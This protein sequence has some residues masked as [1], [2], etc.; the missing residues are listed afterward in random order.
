M[1]QVDNSQRHS[2]TQSLGESREVLGEG[3]NA[4]S[5]MPMPSESSLVT[6][7][8]T[9][10]QEKQ[11][12]EEEDKELCVSPINQTDNDNHFESE[13]EIDNSK[14]IKEAS[15]RA[16]RDAVAMKRS[17]S[18]L[19]DSDN[20]G[21]DNFLDEEDIEPTKL[22]PRKSDATHRYMEEAS[23]EASLLSPNH[24]LLAPS[25]K[26]HRKRSSVSRDV[27]DVRL[28][29][30]SSQGL[31]DE[32][33][34]GERGHFL[35]MNST[36]SEGPPMHTVLAMP[37][38]EDSKED[39]TEIEDLYKTLE[40]CGLSTP[41]ETSDSKFPDDVVLLHAI[42]R[43]FCDPAVDIGSVE[44][45]LDMERGEDAQSIKLPVDVVI[46]RPSKV[47][48]KLLGPPLLSLP[49]NF[50]MGLF[51]ILIR[52]LTNDTDAE[53]NTEILA[54]CP[55][56]DETFAP[57][58]MGGPGILRRQRTTSTASIKR[59]SSF[60]EMSFN[61]SVEARKAD[62]MYT[63]VRL[64]RNWTTAVRQMLHLLRRILQH[65]SRYS[66]LLPPLTRLI[67]LLCSG[68]I[69]V[70]ELRDLLSMAAETKTAPKVQL[71]LVRALTVAAAGAS[72]SSFLVG[73]ASPSHFFSF[74]SGPGMRRKVYL[75][76]PWPFKNDLGMALWFR[77]EYFSK[78]ST[79]LRV[80]DQAGNG[81]EISLLPLSR[82]AEGRPT[83]TVLAIS[84]LEE[85]KVVNSI[86]VSKCILHPRVWYHVGI[87]HTRSRL[88]GVFSLGSREQVSVMLDGKN[89]LT[90]TLKFPK[91]EESNNTSLHLSFGDD[92]DGQTGGLYIFNAPV[93]DATFRALS[94]ITAGTNGA[95]P[96]RASAHG[97]W[98]ARLGDIARKSKVLDLN[99]R[100]DDVE[101]IVLSRKS[102]SK[103]SLPVSAIVDL[104]EDDET[105]ESGPL[106]KANFKSKLYVVWDPRR[107]E[108]NVALELHS[109][110][111]V[112]IDPENIQ[113]WTI[114]GAQ[115][116][117]S[118]VGGV[119]ALL[120]LFRSMLAGGIDNSWNISEENQKATN[121]S[122]IF[123]RCNLCNSIPD[124]ILLL[125]SFVR[126]HS[127]NAREMLRCGAVDIIEQLLHLNK[128]L[129]KGRSCLP[130]TSLVAALSTFPSLSA[131]LVKS[132]LE[133]RSACSHYVG[134][135][136]KVFSRLL[137][138]L[139]LWFGG[140]GS[141]VCLYPEL[142]PVLSSVTRNNPEKVRD[143]IGIKDMTQLIKELIVFEV[144]LHSKTI[145]VDFVQCLTKLLCSKLPCN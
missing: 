127:Q 131:R 22:A 99:M 116:L 106:S 20:D 113:P 13:V 138:N 58:Q 9:T 18:D 69:A 112:H 107:K 145:M 59:Q 87:R 104:E 26:L 27:I 93:S 5:S 1:E 95:V 24:H 77:A 128:K 25:G 97:A 44:R 109:G 63:M 65:D 78:S 118:S 29:D 12:D 120:P 81:T 54:S 117:I 46:Q 14:L 103:D 80:T 101:D 85:G 38:E 86:N 6:D 141:G 31:T 33:L 136:T 122:S 17:D 119:Q 3:Q 74:V 83:A 84:I 90:E 37:F 11:E 60:S 15:R 7:E 144:R 21:A 64:Q 115:D 133:L 142:L 143:C 36:E 8:E 72:R 61:R 35:R 126:D 51:R 121:S 40:L 96:R 52:V 19:S 53:Y 139:P 50:A 134:L 125:A 89:M 2:K 57:S 132:L 135:E 124:L 30:A 130:A 48:I 70:D 23:F 111:H 82:R 94:E 34:N 41:S 123:D 10:D 66:Y 79:I 47:L 45:V 129:G 4:E 137:F 71:L 114:Q 56:Y 108:A 140:L 55:W 75:K 49:Q 43:D 76:N 67:G 32:I 102:G 88:K 28:S 92:F 105:L 73:K 39:S 62:Q 16:I 100:R 91:V 110:A 42:F 68:S 98:D